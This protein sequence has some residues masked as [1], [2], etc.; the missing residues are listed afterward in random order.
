MSKIVTETISKLVQNDQQLINALETFIK[1]YKQ[2]KKI[3]YAPLF[4]FSNRKLGV[5]E[6]VVKYL[7]ENANLNYHQ[8]A[9]MLKRDDR[10]IWCS[11]NN[12]S[13]KMKEKFSDN[14]EHNV[15][16]E[17]FS[18]RALS[19]LKSLIVHLKD[20]GFTFKQIALMLNRSYKT[21]WITYNK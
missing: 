2:Q 8:I 13:K 3:Q 18:D 14:Y 21:I 11:Y 10:T 17:I 6:A 5:L 19:P 15:D 16:I 4:I 12:A 20:S 1:E 7:R 9:L